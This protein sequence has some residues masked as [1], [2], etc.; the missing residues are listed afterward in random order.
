MAIQRWL[1]ALYGRHIRKRFD[2]GAG[3]GQIAS[4]GGGLAIA[5]RRA[6]RALIPRW[7]SIST[8]MRMSHFD[9]MSL[10]QVLLQFELLL[11]GKYLSRCTLDKCKQ[12][13]WE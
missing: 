10:S 8:I 13:R 5:R 4:P 9:L 6:L 12:P 11:A 1:G 3:G 2:R 7:N